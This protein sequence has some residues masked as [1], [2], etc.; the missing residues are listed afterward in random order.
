MDD[1]RVYRFELGGWT[2]GCLATGVQDAQAYIRQLY[3][4]RARYIGRWHGEAGMGCGHITPA[5]QE[6]ISAKYAKDTE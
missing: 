6:L 3:G 5:R 2:I 4:G 1:T